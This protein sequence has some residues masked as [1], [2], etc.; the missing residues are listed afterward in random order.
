MD[1]IFLIFYISLNLFSLFITVDFFP[2]FYKKSVKCQRLDY[3]VRNYSFLL[4]YLHVVLLTNTN[5]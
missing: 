5:N 2:M 4:L 3:V 1:V